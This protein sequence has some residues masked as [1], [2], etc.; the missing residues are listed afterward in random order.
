MQSV[1]DSAA[2]NGGMYLFARRDYV[3]RSEKR[4]GYN[5]G[6]SPKGKKPKRKRRR[7][8]GFYIFITLLMCILFWPV[9]MYLLWRR[10]L[11]WKT[12]A[13]CITSVL[14]LFL[15]IT[16]IGFGL[17]VQTEDPRITQMQDSVNDF[18]DGAV[19]GIANAYTVICDRAVTAWNGVT[20]VADALSGVSIAQIANNESLLNTLDTVSEWA[21]GVHDFLFSEKESADPSAE[22]SD[23]PAVTDEPSATPTLEPTPTPTATPRPTVVVPEVTTEDGKLPIGLPSGTPDPDSGSTLQGGILSRDGEWLDPTPAPT[24]VPTET[25]AA[26]DNSQTTPTPSDNSVS[27]T[28]TVG[29]TASVGATA[30]ASTTPTASATTSA[31][32]VT[33]DPELTPKPASE[34]TVY[35]YPSGV[36]YHMHSSCTK[37]NG[38][39]AKT[40]GEAIAAGKRACRTCNPADASILEA[41]NVVW[42]DKDQHFHLSDECESFVGDWTLKTI[43]DALNS[44]ATPCTVCKADLYMTSCGFVVPTPT[45][46]PTATPEP[47]PTPSPTPSPTPEPTPVPVTPSMALKP[48]AKAIVY[49]SSNGSFYHTASTCKNM[50]GSS[51]YTLGESVAAGFRSCK[52]CA[53]PLAE[54]VDEHCLWQDVD[55]LCHTTDECLR[56]ADGK[57]TLIPRDEALESGYEGCVLCGADEYLTAN[58]TISEYPEYVEPTADP[59]K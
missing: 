22:P 2:K 27:A 16:L 45:P 3:M 37:M 36:G 5:Y 34:A 42:V 25:P 6:G 43:E 30:T 53:A 24:S 56:F 31:P 50:S 55:G 18:L 46:E 1:I 19:E 44:G 35:Y 33:I 29:T 13:K 49:H 52:R 14:T 48:A 15:C 59:G 20:D 47:T 54:Y 28:A 51:P 26:T 12:T 9:G 23:S 41:E 57:F 11:R 8:S 38:A 7:A 21:N 32:T 58:T 39:P 4:N 17:T 40:L 10:K